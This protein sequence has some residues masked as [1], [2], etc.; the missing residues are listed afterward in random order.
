MNYIL[1]LASGVSAFGLVQHLMLGRSRPLQ[2]PL[3]T[4]EDEGALKADAWFGRHIQTILLAAMALVY[5]NASR[6][7]DMLDV[8]FWVS[9]ISMLATILR[10]ALGVHTAAPRFDI[11]AW[12]WMGLA[13]VLG[14]AGPV[15]W[16]AP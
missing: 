5:G 9:L 10:L 13:A 7:P 15:L 16:P 2:Q 3:T 1:L 8:V 4:P 11:R 12:A 14:L 6:Q